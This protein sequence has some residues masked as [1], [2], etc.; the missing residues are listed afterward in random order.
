MEILRFL[1]G[2][3]F[4]YGAFWGGNFFLLF[5]F[6]ELL[7]SFFTGRSI[8]SFSPISEILSMKPSLQFCIITYLIWTIILD[9]DIFGN[10]PKLHKFIN[11][12]M[13]GPEIKFNNTDITQQ[14]TKHNNTNKS[15][16]NEKIEKK[17]Q[18]YRKKEI[19]QETK[20][21]DTFDEFYEKEVNNI[22]GNYNDKELESIKEVSFQ[23]IV[24]DKNMMEKIYEN[25]DIDY[26]E[27]MQD[28]E[29]E[30]RKR[31]K[32]HRSFEGRLA[33]SD[34]NYLKS[35]LGYRCMCCGLD[36][37]E[38]YGVLGN[39]YIELHHL[40]PYA[41]LNENETRILN[42]DDFAV[43][44]PNCHRMIHR[45]DNPADINLLKKIIKS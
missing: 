39:K 34:K 27:I 41:D 30:E 21:Q 32:N 9:L 19:K 38:L 26:K 37:S 40:I 29:I 42:A 6:I 4:V 3:Y 43:L 22:V 33:T 8:T 20:I 18:E 45:L 7:I 36:L 24:A 17:W 25:T 23:N 44:C 28:Y 1:F 31:T 14:Y 11:Y 15:K 16:R 35:I 10:F 13:D 2:L 12:L 5:L